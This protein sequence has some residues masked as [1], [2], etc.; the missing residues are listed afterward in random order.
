MDR[1]ISQ[2]EKKREKKVSYLKIASGVIILC[3]ALYFINHFLSKSIDRNDIL[4]DVVEKG[5]VSLTIRGTGKIE[6]TI[7]KAITS[8][9][10]SFIESTNTYLGQEI[11]GDQPLLTINTAE[12]ENQLMAMIDEA[13]IK[14]S[15]INKEKLRLSKELFNLKKDTEI[16]QLQ[17]QRRE[18]ELKSEEKLLS[19]GGS[20][21][22]NVQQAKTLLS[23][24][25]LKQEQLAHDLLIKEKAI[26][27]EIR[28]LELALSIQIKNIKEQ[29]RKLEK[30]KAKAGMSGVITYLNDKVGASIS[31]GEVLARVANMEQFRIR[32]RISDQYVS[33]LSIG[34]DVIANTSKAAY[35]GS[36]SSISPS[37]DNGM[38]TV[39]IQLE[40]QKGLELLRP[41]MVTDLSI[42]REQHQNVLR[43]KNKGA[44][45]GKLVEEIFLVKNGQAQKVKVKTGYRNAEWVEVQSALNEG[46]SVIISP[47]DKF[48]NVPQININ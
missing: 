28:T 24:E 20:T 8:P 16:N 47:T 48:K 1:L 7:Q 18:E 44:F 15:H 32:G 33:V 21:A 40:E 13:D 25:R 12:A 42:I 10:S 43:V 26:T 14:R 45:K 29:E 30:A 37:S 5:D 19:I 39:F 38:I 36:I 35:F 6:P 4:I 17:L 2:Q 46:D 31:E 3:G 27:Q 22:E 34:M 11:K 23:V 41:D 9:F